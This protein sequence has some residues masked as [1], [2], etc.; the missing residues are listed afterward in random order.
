MWEESPGHRRV[1]LGPLLVTRVLILMAAAAGSETPG[2]RTASG[3]FHPN[4]P[5]SDESIGMSDAASSEAERLKAVSMDLVAYEDGPASPT[6]PLAMS[7]PCGPSGSPTDMTLSEATHLPVAGAQTFGGLSED[8]ELGS[9]LATAYCKCALPHNATWVN[10]LYKTWGSIPGRP[11]AICVSRSRATRPPASA[12]P[13]WVR[14][15][16]PGRRGSVS[17][18]R[19][20]LGTPTLPSRPPR[21][22]GSLLTASGP[23]RARRQ[24]AGRAPMG[25]AT[26]YMTSVGWS[27][28]TK[29]A[30]R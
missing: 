22:R 3:A 2:V 19:M 4:V 15:E 13:L 23:A 7:R 29:A 20:W 30:I 6:D 8:E 17:A 28:R 14:R 25:T 18:R 27:S 16:L 26:G 11:W 21:K 9:E 5:V 24:G 10:V 12:A 1:P